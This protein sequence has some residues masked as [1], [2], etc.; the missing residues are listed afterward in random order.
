MNLVEENALKAAIVEQ[1]GRAV[2]GN[3]NMAWEFGLF[4]VSYE[5]STDNRPPTY[6]ISAFINNESILNKYD[7]A[8]YAEYKEGLKAIN[9][10]R[11][12]SQ[13]SAAHSTVRQSLLLHK[14]KLRLFEHLEHQ[15][16]DHDIEGFVTS[17]IQMHKDHHIPIREIKLQHIP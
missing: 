11:L 16:S 13:A 14:L 9:R 2:R 3:L 10:S 1:L 4:L 6:T 7:P 15:P 12:G 5:R 8:V 17:L